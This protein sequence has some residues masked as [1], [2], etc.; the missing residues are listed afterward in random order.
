MC[1]YFF[2]L[3]SEPTSTS[4]DIVWRPFTAVN[5]YFLHILADTDI[6]TRSSLESSLVNPYGTDIFFWEDIY[7]KHFSDAESNWVIKDRNDDETTVDPT[8]ADP[9]TAAPTTAAPTTDASSTD[10]PAATT[11]APDGD[12]TTEAPSSASTA[13]GY[14]LLIVTLF[15]LLSHLHSSQL[16]S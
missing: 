6:G 3:Y 11:P 15:T 9:T 10:A 16:L 12:A 7:S 2:F 1:S 14:T 4:S 8:T 13:V 5:S